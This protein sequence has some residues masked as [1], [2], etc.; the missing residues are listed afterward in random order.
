[1]VGSASLWEGGWTG[2]YVQQAVDGRRDHQLLKPFRTLKPITA[3]RA[4]SLLI[5]DAAGT[6]DPSGK[7]NS[8]KPP[9]TQLPL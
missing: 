8:V 7:E 3:T 4:G 6:G 1:M 9:I 5:S 2:G